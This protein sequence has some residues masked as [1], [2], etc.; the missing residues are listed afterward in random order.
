MGKGNSEFLLIL[1]LRVV[2]VWIITNHS[3]ILTIQIGLMRFEDGPSNE[4]P[5][6]QCDKTEGLT[7]HVTNVCCLRCFVNLEIFHKCALLLK[8]VETVFS[9]K[10]AFISLV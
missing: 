8:N 5:S 4:Y 2:E 10:I 3:K 7:Y 6:L 1:Q 9:R